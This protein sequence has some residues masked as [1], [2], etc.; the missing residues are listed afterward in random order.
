MASLNKVFLIGNVGRDPKVTPTGDT[1]IGSI[2]L[3]TTRKYKKGG[4]KMEET[5]WHTITLFGAQAE[6]AENYIRKGA[7]LWVEGRIR[8]RV[9]QNESGQ[10]SYRTEIVCESLQFVGQAP[11]A[12]QSAQDAGGYAQTYAPRQSSYQANANHRPMAINNG[13][14]TMEED[15]PF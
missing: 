5:E 3:A 9:Y 12:E 2:S 6:F 13:M 8:T 14:D 4:E 10:K 15:I 7:Q 1:K 11:R